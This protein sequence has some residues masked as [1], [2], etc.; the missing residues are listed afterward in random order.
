FAAFHGNSALDQ[1]ADELADDGLFSSAGEQVIVL[2]VVAERDEAVP[3]LLAYR[4]V[5][6]AEK[7]ELQLGP[8]FRHET[9]L[10]RAL[11]L[12]LEDPPRRALDGGPRPGDHVAEHD[13]RLRQPRRAAKSLPVGEALEV[14]VALLPARE[15][16]TRNRVHFHVAREHVVAGVPAVLR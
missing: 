9:H 8:A 16:V 10:P 12:A 2:D 15:G 11:D 4:V 6:L 5:S 1:G 14:A 13:R 7:V 3:V